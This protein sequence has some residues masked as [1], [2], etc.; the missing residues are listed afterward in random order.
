M[1]FEGSFYNIQKIEHLE[2]SYQV[3]IELNAQHPIYEGHFPQQAVVPGVCTL[4]MIKECIGQIL[5][6]DVQLHAIKECKYTSALIP[7][8]D[9]RIII[10]ICFIGDNN[11]QSEVKRFDSQEIV[12][13]LKASYR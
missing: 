11:V 8:N 10:S 3:E 9:F 1:K 13:K 12:L 2:N 4:T 6:K 7:Q 5:S